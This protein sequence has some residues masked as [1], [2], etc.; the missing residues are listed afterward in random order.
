MSNNITIEQLKLV[1]QTK[2]DI[3]KILI[4]KLNLIIELLDKKK[5]NER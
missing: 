5:A 2:Q 1:E 4:D 3:S